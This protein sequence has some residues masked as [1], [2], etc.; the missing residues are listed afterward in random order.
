VAWTTIARFQVQCS[1]PTRTAAASGRLA[2]R[3]TAGTRMELHSESRHRTQD[4]GG[5]NSKFARLEL[6]PQAA[7]GVCVASPSNR[8][9]AAAA[10][11]SSESSSSCRDLNTCIGLGLGE[12]SGRR[13]V[14]N[15]EA[16]RPVHGAPSV[17]EAAMPGPTGASKPPPGP[18]RRVPSAAGGHWQPG[19]WRRRRSGGG[20]RCAGPDSTR[21]P[22]LGSNR[23]SSLGCEDAK[24]SSTH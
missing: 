24:P 2:A 15:S 14:P 7:C 17:E 19:M 18:R 5:V 21:A 12:D 13:A 8:F 1:Q 22:A 20:G 3:A 6:T 10:V 4:R 23:T 9:S 11:V 16:P